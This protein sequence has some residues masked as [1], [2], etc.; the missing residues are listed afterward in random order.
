MQYVRS[1]TVVLLNLIIKT[2]PTGSLVYACER[3]MVLQELF[4]ILI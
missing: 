2:V 3:H 4:L 1:D